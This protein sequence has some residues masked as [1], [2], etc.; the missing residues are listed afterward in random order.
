VFALEPLGEDPV[1]TRGEQPRQLVEMLAG[2]QA[3]AAEPGQATQIVETLDPG[4]GRRPVE[5]R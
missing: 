4:I 2:A 3:D 5:D 1:R